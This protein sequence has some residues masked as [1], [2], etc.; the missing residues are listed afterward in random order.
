MF[1]RYNKTMFATLIIHNIDQ[2]IDK[3]LTQ[4]NLNE[5]YFTKICIKICENTNALD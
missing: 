4:Q 3:P 2:S 1:Y 5:K